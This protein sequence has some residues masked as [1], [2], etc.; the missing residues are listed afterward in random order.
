LSE[1][2]TQTEI[3]I[4]RCFHRAETPDDLPQLRLL[5][6]KLTT[7]ST[8]TQVLS[9]SRVARVTNHQLIELSTNYFAIVFSHNSFT[10]K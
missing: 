2:R 10:Y 7:R 4:R 9:H 8:V 3:E 6:V 5:L 1:S